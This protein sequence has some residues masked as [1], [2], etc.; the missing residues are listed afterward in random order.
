MVA[1][2]S[3][4]WAS[5]RLPSHGSHRLRCR[6]G[7]GYRW[8]S[9]LT[10]LLYTREQ[11]HSFTAS[12]EAARSVEVGDSVYHPTHHQEQ[13]AIAACGRLGKTA[14]D[15]DAQV[16]LTAESNA[17]FQGHR[18]PS[19]HIANGRIIVHVSGLQIHTPPCQRTPAS[20]V[21]SPVMVQTT[22]APHAA[23]AS[24]SRSSAQERNFT[25][26]SRRSVKPSPAPH[27]RLPFPL[28]AWMLGN[29][30]LRDSSMA[31]GIGRIPVLGR[32]AARR[33]CQREQAVC[34]R[35]E[36]KEERGGGAPVATPAAECAPELDSLEE[37]IGRYRELGR[38]P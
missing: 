24:P 30:S 8:R 26:P 3:K 31:A 19:P 12:P 22:A 13:H 14:P 7:S 34:S 35:V 2:M 4:I 5:H 10:L 29:S 37:C 28:V 33:R 9:S 1:L 27:F 38:W 36:G 6:R 21:L 23:A 25:D 11:H 17:P 15:L 18:F 20:W 32:C 16:L